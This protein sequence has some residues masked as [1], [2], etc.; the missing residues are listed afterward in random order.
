MKTCVE[1]IKISEIVD[2]YQIREDDSVIGWGGKLNITPSYQRE[3]IRSG[4]AKWQVPLIQSVYRGHPINLIY[5]AEEIPGF[6]SV[7]DGQQR[8]RTIC[9]F[10]KDN[11]FAVNL[12]GE[13]Y[14]YDQ[15]A[16]NDKMHARFMG[17][18]VLVCFCEG[19][20]G[21]DYMM[22]FKTI[23]KGAAE[24]KNQEVR[25][26][27]CD[28]PWVASAKTYFSSRTA[29]Q[30]M[31]CNDLLGGQRNRQQHL[32]RILR[33]RLNTDDDRH[34]LTYMQRKRNRVN[35]EDL[36][37]Y[38]IQVHTW[39]ASLFD[40]ASAQSKRSY[41]GRL[42]KIMGKPNWGL[43]Y[44]NHGEQKFD[45]EYT[46]T[47]AQEML[48]YPEV[49]KKSGIYEYILGGEV[50]PQILDPRLFDEDTRERVW[51]QQGKLCA[52]QIQPRPDFKCVD[53]QEDE[54]PWEDA[55]ADHITSW[56][57]GGRTVIENCQ[58]LCRKCNQRKSSK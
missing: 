5:F 19:G 34:I 51:L 58:V 48:D 47:R 17:Y 3:Y 11:A 21:D 37:E 42:R 18:E 35:A 6:Y 1:Q 31:L 43:L 7:L 44:A 46:R 8:L 14:I 53:P 4:D 24:L 40:V 33:W 15:V 39:V 10:I 32:E 13:S 12:D 54:M 23:N 49:Q 36:W 41:A 30:T 25:N 56:L 55:H 20:S 57:E 2:G 27:L 29:G 26:A 28:G 16:V 38:Y 52:Y 45:T 50:N 22:W 9:D